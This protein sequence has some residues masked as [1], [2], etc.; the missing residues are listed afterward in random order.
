MICQENPFNKM[1]GFFYACLFLGFV[2][3]NLIKVHVKV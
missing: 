3:Q 1:R 2:I